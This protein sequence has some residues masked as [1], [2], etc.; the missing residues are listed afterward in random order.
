LR[1][2]DDFDSNHSLSGW[3]RNQTSNCSG[4]NNFLGGPCHLSYDE[5][6]KLYEKLP[7][8]SQIRINARLHMFDDWKGEKA[9]MK[10][11]DKVVWTKTGKNSALKGSNICGSNSN[12]PAF[13]V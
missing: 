7:A 9:F 13:A 11:D 2:H 4:F 3:S 6:T 8:H 12:D 10:V 5:A 1:H